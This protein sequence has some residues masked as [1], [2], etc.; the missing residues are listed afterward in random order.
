MDVCAAYQ[1]VLDNAARFGGDPTRIVVAGE[2]AGANLAL[3][4]ALLTCTPRPEAWANAVFRRG[5][6][7]RAVVAACGLLEVSNMHRY[8]DAWRVIKTTLH[9]IRRSYLPADPRWD[10]EH[11]LANPLHILERRE[12]LTRPLPPV[13]VPCGTIDPIVEDS[14][15]LE[16][17]LRVLGVPHEA[18]YYEGEYHAFHAMWWREQSRLCWQD[19]MAFLARHLSHDDTGRRSAAA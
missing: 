15:R 3:S 11:D 8:Q 10:G 13:F 6:T 2:S 12:A 16:R 5:V 19:T 17:A 7:P 9:D 14:V 18:R 4:L 1:W